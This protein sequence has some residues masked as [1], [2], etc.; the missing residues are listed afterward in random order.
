MKTIKLLFIL[1]I[2]C[3]SVCA[4]S[5]VPIPKGYV[6]LGLPSGTYWKENN[7]DGYYTY[8]EA[9]KQFGSNI[10][11][12]QQVEELINNCTF[13]CSNNVIKVTG[14]NGNYIYLPK[15]G[16]YSCVKL[17]DENYQQ[18]IK[19]RYVDSNTSGGRYWTATVYDNYEAYDLTLD[20][21]D[22]N[23][24]ITFHSEKI[25]KLSVRLVG[26]F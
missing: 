3:S 6:D 25:S 4:Q 12:L 26:Q 10:P 16:F 23:I 11:T 13:T 14:R 18:Y 5:I 7:E 2:I 24:L 22:K 20:S 9:I 1:S 17:Y 19:C 8:A 15:L 21:G